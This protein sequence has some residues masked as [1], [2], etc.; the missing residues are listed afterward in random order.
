MH[1]SPTQALSPPHFTPGLCHRL[2]TLL[3]PVQRRAVLAH[4][5]AWLAPCPARSAPV[6]YQGLS[7][8]GEFSRASGIGETARIMATVA[9]QLGVPVWRTDIPPPVDSRAELP[10]PTDDI[11]PACAP[12]VVHI[13]APM[14]PLAFLRLPRALAKTRRIV[15]YWAWELPSV[16]PDWHSGIRFVHDVWAPSHF[17]AAALEPLAPGRVRVVPPPLADAPPIP[18]HLDRSAF[19]LPADAVVTLVS[20]NLASS[21]ARKNPFAAIA[22]FRTAF[23]D[24]S[25]RVLVLKIGHPDRA[26]AD[27][28]R[29]RQAADA[30]N[31]RLETRILPTDD[32]HALTACCDIVLS[33]HRSEGFGLVPAEAML[34]GKPVV[35]TG[36]SGNM[37]YMSADSAAL[38]GY[39]LIPVQDERMVYRDSVWAEPHIGQAAEHL[40]RLADD[41]Q[42]R[43]ALGAR[44]QDRARRVLTRAPLAAALRD[45]GLH[46]RI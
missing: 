3:P 32:S 35:A 33:L 8:A 38:V 30:P 27:F 42:A 46:V 11:P 36:W 9:A 31:I 21:C 4:V 24:R 44:G 28:E 10:L 45:I 20:F 15:G 1:A 5:A 29:L 19:G 41:S 22:A 37:D 43:R 40:R 25:D 39:H 2:W 17:T 18:S 14:L 7:V 13:N 26:P 23:G 34:L 16:P 12:M 6:P